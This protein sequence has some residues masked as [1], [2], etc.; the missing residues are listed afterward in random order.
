DSSLEDHSDRKGALTPQ[1]QD[2]DQGQDQDQVRRA[3]HT[4]Q[5]VDSSGIV[6]VTGAPAGQ[7]SPGVTLAR[8]R[9]GFIS[10]TIW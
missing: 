8:S 4:L 1:D 3:A 2:Q 9:A 5:P 6:T 7:A 10:S